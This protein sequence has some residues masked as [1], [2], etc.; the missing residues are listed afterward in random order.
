MFTEE[1]TLDGTVIYVTEVSTWDG[2]G[3]IDPITKAPVPRHV[4]NSFE[5]R[6]NAKTGEIDFF[7]GVTES[8]ALVKAFND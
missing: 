1:K 6:R 7:Y 2:N 5:P 3:Y 8:G 4:L